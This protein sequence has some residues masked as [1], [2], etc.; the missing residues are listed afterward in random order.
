MLL[1]IER[2]GGRQYLQLKEAI[3]CLSEKNNEKGNEFHRESN[4]TRWLDFD[5]D[6][7]DEVKEGM[8]MILHSN[9]T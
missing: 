6:K 8:K 4:F 9:Y 2:S 7:L 1:N 3:S 5:I